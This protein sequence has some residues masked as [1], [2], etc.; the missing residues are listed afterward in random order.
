MCV[1]VCVYEHVSVFGFSRVNT[2]LHVT[3]GLYNIN[4]TSSNIAITH[5][6]MLKYALLFAIYESFIQC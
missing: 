1:C 5:T 6:I 3:N 4:S 2:N